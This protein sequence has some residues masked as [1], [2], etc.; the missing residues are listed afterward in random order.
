MINL[1]R[2]FQVLVCLAHTIT[3][4]VM[5]SIYASRSSGTGTAPVFWNVYGNDEVS[6]NIPFGYLIFA[7]MVFKGVAGLFDLFKLYSVEKSNRGCRK[8]FRYIV[9]AITEPLLIITLYMCLATFELPELILHGALSCCIVLSFFFTLELAKYLPASADDTLTSKQVSAL[10]DDY[11]NNPD[12]VPKDKKK[13][14][15]LMLLTASYLLMFMGFFVLLFSAINAGFAIYRYELI[16]DSPTTGAPVN[17]HLKA[18]VYIYSSILLWLA[19]YMNLYIYSKLSGILNGCLLK[20]CCLCNYTF[21]CFNFFDNGNLEECLFTI[22]IDLVKWMVVPM[23]LYF[24]FIR[25]TI[26]VI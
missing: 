17:T 14:V 8:I 16:E 13:A 20:L 3:G 26:F 19:L 25:D 9:M 21:H 24:G 7:A 11:D 1:V 4:I 18:A 15:D 6:R 2:G 10:L 5:C 23:L 12:T 22:I